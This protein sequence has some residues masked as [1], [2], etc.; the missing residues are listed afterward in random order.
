MILSQYCQFQVEL[1]PGS[2]PSQS[3]AANDKIFMR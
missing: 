2:D 1:K 3:T